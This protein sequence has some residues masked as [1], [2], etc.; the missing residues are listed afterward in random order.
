MS[1]KEK[2]IDALQFFVTELSSQAL[3]H[4]IHGRIFNSQGFTKLGQK[5]LDH[6]VEEREW[7]SKFIDRILDLDGCPKHEVPHT[8]PVYGDIHE[9]LKTD[10]KVSEDGLKLLDSHI[11]CETLD[12]KTFDLFKEYYIDEE[13]D[14]AWTSQQLELIER[15]GINNY[16]LGQM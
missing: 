8:L 4:E 7:V 11:D 5:Y 13:D 16:L 9:Y 3:S 1:N 12:Y 2:T 10:N 14:M 6:A 15:F